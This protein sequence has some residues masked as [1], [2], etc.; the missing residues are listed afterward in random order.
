MSCV[1][2]GVMKL[3]VALFLLLYTPAQTPISGAPQRLPQVAVL[4]LGKTEAAEHALQPIIRFFESSST[5]KLIDSLQ[6]RAAARGAGYQGSLNMT[7]DEARDLGAALGCDFFLTGEARVLRRSASERPKYFEAYV[8]LF[9][10]S[11]RTGKLIKWEH[12]SFDAES[13]AAAESLLMQ[14]IPGRAAHFLQEI[15]SAAREEPALRAA[16]RLREETI[17]IAELPADDGLHPPGFRPPQPYRRLLP[18]YPQIAARAEATATIDVLVEID[19]EGEVKRVDVARWGG[20]GLDEE[21]V[22]TVKRMHFRPAMRNSMP[23]AV[24]SL[25]R[26]NFRPPQRN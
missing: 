14:A 22:E 5:V 23:V 16:E 26:Y 19:A 7:L 1:F 25:L 15:I 24:R 12:L 4:D 20:F 18:R 6:S 13:P 21:V 17:L 8:S 9:L 3:S 2:F 11:T 10:V